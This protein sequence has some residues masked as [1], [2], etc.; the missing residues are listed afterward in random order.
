MKLFLQSEAAECGL[1]CL[2]MVASHH[3]LGQDL[4]ELRR[5]FPISLKGAKLASLISHAG[6]L[7]FS[8][9][10]LKLEMEHLG[11]LSLPCILHWDLNHFVVLK[12]VGARS[13]VVLDPAI[14]ERRLSLQEMSSHFTGVALELTPNADFKPAKQAPR[15]SLASLTGRVSGLKRSLLQILAV[16][17]VLEVFAIVAPLFN[18]LVVDEVLSSGDFELLGVLL[19]GFGLLLLIQTALSLGRSWMV[20]LLSQTLALQWQSNVFAHLIR[21]PTA[22]F[23]KRHLGDITSRFGAVNAIQRSL[24]TAAIEAVLD[25]VMALIA[26]AMMLLYSVPLTAIVLGAVAAYGALRWV[27]YRPFRDASAER[28]VIAAK[29]NTHFLETLRAITP[30]KLYGRE[31]E[32]RA[33][34]QNLIVDVQ[35]RDVRTAKMSMA[36]QTANT[37]IFGLENLAV[38]WLGARTI[39]QGQQSHAVALTVGMLFAFVSY[40]T[41]FTGRVG[42]LIDYGV[43]LRMLSLHGERLADIVLEAPEQDEVPHSELDHLVPSLEL[44][45]V[46]F[47][48]AEGEPWILKNANFKVEAG[49]NVAVTG[50]S[51]AGKTTLLKIILGLLPPTEGEVLFGGVPV[52]HLGVRNFRRQIGTVMQ[53]DALLT[54]S[55]ADNI[56][57]F[58]SHP[59]MERIQQCAA[60]AQ[61]HEDIRRMP[62]G[63]QTLVG[64]L[65]SGLSGGQKQ[66]LLLARA[67][68]KKP[69]VLALDEATSHLDIA[70]ERAVTA[71]LSQM[72]LTRLVIAHRPETI[73][74]AQRVVQVREGQVLEL[75]RQVSS[76]VPDSTSAL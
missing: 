3:G 48:Y 19:L 25:G 16:A 4:G 32:R 74:G 67:I 5:R 9:R 20:L 8:A 51:G 35:N 76:G 41:Q 58:D 37:L 6:S 66:R 28:L 46:S 31:D 12:K 62:M 26:L 57:F 61:L 52:R 63:Y 36:F 42:K 2:A 38:L 11:Q 53:E 43:E 24:T 55:L 23:E 7:G 75:A 59:D 71:A 40:K 70:N 68:Y 60:Q 50:P 56:S 47:R 45:N 72:K 14:G 13:C 65:G 30:L 18:Q 29:E 10:P 34:W 1:A 17:V 69:R 27:A 44:R 73:A 39:L 15:L 33:R 64:D 21:L 54:G 22:F 49:E